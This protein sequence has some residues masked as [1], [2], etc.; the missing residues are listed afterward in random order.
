M[1]TR[2][3]VFV[4]DADVSVRESLEL[5]I[6]RSGWQPKTFA[7]AQEFLAQPR[8]SAPCCLVLD[9]ALPGL[10]GLDLQK[11]V[12]D[13][14]DMPVIFLTGSGDVAMTVQAMKA[15]AVEFLTK[16]FRA[17]VLVNAI[18]EALERSWQALARETAL[19][20]LRD[21]YSSLSRREREVMSLVVS[22]LLNKQVGGELGISEITV[23]AHRGQVM[24][25]MHADSLPA[26]VKMAA[27]LDLPAARPA[28]SVFQATWPEA[29]SGRSPRAT[30][31]SRASAF[32]ASA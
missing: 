7:S 8:V 26:L 11:L 2:P 22:G 1:T 9:V 17:D 27:R 16:P 24:R 14:T 19:K 12:A 18:R 4:V 13:R 23:K 20:S 28:E 6:D 10:S 31:T 3:I 21:S 25:K 5:L 30:D 29:A 15:G 32:R